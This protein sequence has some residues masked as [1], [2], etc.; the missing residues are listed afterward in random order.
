MLDGKQKQTF[1]ELIYMR[2]MEIQHRPSEWTKL[3]QSVRDE[4]FKYAGD[5][6]EMLGKLDL[7]ARPAGEIAA[8]RKIAKDKKEAVK[9]F[10]KDWIRAN[11][12]VPKNAAALFPCDELIEQIFTKYGE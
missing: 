10:A 11:F 5:I 12:T 8:A 3:D 6:E 7:E 1:A 4:Y 9:N 2:D